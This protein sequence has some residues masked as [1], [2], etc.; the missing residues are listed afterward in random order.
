MSCFN[1]QRILNDFESILNHPIRVQVCFECPFKILKFNTLAHN[2]AWF[3]NF[4]LK[5]KFSFC[6]SLI[7]RLLQ[8]SLLGDAF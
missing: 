6:T 3:Y 8:A 7:I 2:K 5:W 1:G 4:I